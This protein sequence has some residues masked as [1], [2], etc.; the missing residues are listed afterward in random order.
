MNKPFKIIM[1][2]SAGS[3]CLLFANKAIANIEYIVP[4]VFGTF[5]EVESLLFLGIGFI[6]ISRLIRHYR[7]QNNVFGR[8]R[9]RKLYGN[10]A[11]TDNAA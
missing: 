4:A 9:Q 6:G 7:L 2:L 5:G 3:V 1:I 10:T 11:T 8:D